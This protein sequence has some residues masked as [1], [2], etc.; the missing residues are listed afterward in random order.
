MSKTITINP[1]SRVEGDLKIY[2]DIADNQVVDARVSGIL[3]RGFENLLLRRDPMD[4]L[5]FSPRICGICSIGQSL[6]ASRLLRQFYQIQ[7]PENAYPIFNTVM[8]AEMIMNHLT[9]FYLLFGVDLPHL[10][11]KSLKMYNAVSQRFSS[12]IGSAF[13]HVIRARKKVL[14]LIGLLAG[15]WPNSLAM[16]PGGITKALTRS[17]LMRVEGV[18]RVCKKFIEDQIL[19][20]SLERWMEIQSLQD[21][22]KWIGEDD[23]Q[24]SDLGLFYQFSREA[25]FEKLGA[26][27]AALLSYGGFENPDGSYFYHSGFHANNKTSPFDAQKVLEGIRYSWFQGDDSKNI[28]PFNETTQTVLTKKEAYSWAKAPRYDNQ[29][30]ETGPLARLVINGDPLAVNIYQEMG[31]NVFSRVLLRF[32]DMILI[33]SEMGR[34]IESINPDKHFYNAH[35]K[36][37]EGEAVGYSEVSRGSLGH[38]M[39]VQ[40]GVITNYQVVSPSTWNFSPKDTKGTS[41]A[42]EQALKNLDIQ[43][44]NDLLEVAHVVRSFDPCLFCTVHNVS[45]KRNNDA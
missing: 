32:H 25:D 17:D 24:N 34:W 40:K 3:F 20:S 8:A 18:W 43:D 7:M 35:E 29:V 11:Y 23:H 33:L 22:E 31:S 5:V 42:V 27:K 21:I 12:R 30:V 36:K 26:S 6:A 45:I 14:E 39:K 1:L 41:G 38:W 10:R 4:A 13:V 37:E 2:I 9:H 44:E 16:Q 28:H 15:K 19:S